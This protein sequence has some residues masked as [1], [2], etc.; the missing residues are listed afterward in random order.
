VN[1]SVGQVSPTWC[2]LMPG[3]GIPVDDVRDVVYV[4]STQRRLSIQSTI[5]WIGG[6]LTESLAGQR[7]AN[8]FQS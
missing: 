7:S 6:R 2:L 8:S 1:V 4:N 3:M 5:Q